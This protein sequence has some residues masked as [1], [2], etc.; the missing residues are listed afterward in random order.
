MAL[1]YNHA[2]CR[3]SSNTHIPVSYIQ[4]CHQGI[5]DRSSPLLFQIAVCTYLSI[6]A[7]LSRLPVVSACEQLVPDL[8][9]PSRIDRY[10][11]AAPQSYNKYTLD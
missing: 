1:H 3:V 4:V 9:L 2:S 7:K 6:Y 11:L 10:L 8:I 5:S